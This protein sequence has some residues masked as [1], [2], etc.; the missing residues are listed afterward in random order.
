MQR[1]ETYWAE[2]QRLGSYNAVAVSLGVQPSTVRRVILRASKRGQINLTAYQNPP[3]FQTGKVTVQTDAAGNVE[4]EWRRIHPEAE[5]VEAWVDDL[6]NR[7]AKAGPK[8]KPPK[9]R[10]D[11][12]LEIPI[13][14]MHVGMRS[15]KPETGYDWDTDKACNMF[16]GGAS[17]LMG[18]APNNTSHVILADLGDFMH[19]D[20]RFGTTERSGNILDMSGSFCEIIDKARDAWVQVIERA[21]ARFASVHVSMVPGN[22]N[23]QSAHW[24]ARIV[25]AYFRKSKHIAIETAPTVHRYHA[26]GRSLFGYSHGH[27]A[28]PADLAVMMATAV[29]TEWAAARH[30]HWRCGHIHHK[31]KQTHKDQGENHGVT[32]ETFPIL[33][34]RDAYHA[35]HGYDAQRLLQGI[36]HHEE[37]GELARHTVHARMLEQVLKRA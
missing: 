9:I 3:G 31:T 26:W 6:C 15:W 13:G 11:M 16:V 36:L 28:K 30:R 5:D 12:A 29:P 8:I 23:T 32:V 10:G 35:E 24:M 18:L 1:W 25:S 33:P 27:L 4:R 14:D 7:A 22:H 37:H 34:P 19:S 17:Y 2:Y 21:A 20:S